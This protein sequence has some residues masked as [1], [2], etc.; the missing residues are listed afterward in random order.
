[1]SDEPKI[2]PAEADDGTDPIFDALW[3]RVLE[4]WDDEKRHAALLDHA[5]R[6]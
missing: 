6:E 5:L 1:M 3:A 2:E 4:A